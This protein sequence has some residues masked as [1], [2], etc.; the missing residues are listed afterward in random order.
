MAIHPVQNV[1]DPVPL[2]SYV[3]VEQS[4]KTQY[5]RLIEIFDHG[6]RIE[7]RHIDKLKKEAIHKFQVSPGRVIGYFVGIV[8]AVFRG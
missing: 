2:T 1:L 4:Q 6:F 8:S 7:I 5:K 3:R